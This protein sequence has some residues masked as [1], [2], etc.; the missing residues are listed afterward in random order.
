MERETHFLS[1]LTP[2]KSKLS[3]SS[4]KTTSIIPA[5][6]KRASSASASPGAYAWISG[7]K[8]WVDNAH[9]GIRNQRRRLTLWN[10]SILLVVRHA[11]VYLSSFLAIDCKFL[12]IVCFK[13]LTLFGPSNTNN[14]RIGSE[15]RLHSLKN[16]VLRAGFNPPGAVC[17][18]INQI[19]RVLYEL[20]FD[21]RYFTYDAST[22]TLSPLYPLWFAI[23]AS[24]ASLD[25]E[26]EQAAG[27]RSL[28]FYFKLR[29]MWNKYKILTS[30]SPGTPIY[31]SR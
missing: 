10:L 4:D 16:R 8:A 25:S 17:E 22:P 5:L 12:V 24:T 31:I 26:C 29:N 13:S 14:G 28:L 30:H 20:L 11:L 6:D 18:C 27:R 19:L 23:N 21:W 9:C 2:P 7:Y 15:S 1:I 3:T